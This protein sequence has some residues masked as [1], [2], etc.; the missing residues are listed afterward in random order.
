MQITA[1]LNARGYENDQ[2]YKAFSL[3][4][5]PLLKVENTI[6]AVSFK[7]RLTTLVISYCF[8][9]LYHIL[10][11]LHTGESLVGAATNGAWGASL[12][13]LKRRVELADK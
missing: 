1:L 7:L 12:T 2:F 5:I 13:L 10:A 4:Q 6:V 3:N 8:L 9:T 11:K